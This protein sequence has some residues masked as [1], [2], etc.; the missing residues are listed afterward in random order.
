MTLVFILCLSSSLSLSFSLSVQLTPLSLSGSSIPE[1]D[2]L[3][4]T[5]REATYPNP[6]HSCC[7]VT[8]FKKY[9]YIC[10]R[11]EMGVFESMKV[12]PK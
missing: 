5:S 9:H 11:K 8:I 10:G 6:L 12:V 3:R 7:S 4:E 2:T 1:N